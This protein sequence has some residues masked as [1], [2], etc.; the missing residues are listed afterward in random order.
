MPSKS[1]KQWLKETL[2]PA[3]E[4]FPERNA[5]FHTDSDINIEPLYDPENLDSRSSGSRSFNYNED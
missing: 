5:K 1:K 3:L 2:G 4:K